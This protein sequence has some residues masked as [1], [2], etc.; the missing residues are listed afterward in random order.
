MQAPI[1]LQQPISELGLSETF[2]RI[3]NRHG[4]RNLQDILNWPVS[5]LLLH[6]GFTYHIYQEL[7]EFLK[8]NELFHLLKTA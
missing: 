2:N 3:A 1:L 6:E 4:F 7:M 8:K 5:V